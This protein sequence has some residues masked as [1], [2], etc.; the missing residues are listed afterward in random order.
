MSFEQF[1][2]NI[3]SKKI[4]NDIHHNKQIFFRWKTKKI[5]YIKMEKINELLPYINKKYNLSYKMKKSTHYAHKHDV[6]YTFM[7]KTLWNDIDKIP[8]KYSYFYN[9]EIK[10]NVEKL[11]GDDIKVLDYT[12]D[13]FISPK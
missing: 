9:D 8:L 13:E 5:E 7:G 6:E 1:I 11:Y 4:K 12:W 10:K 3:L 2:Q